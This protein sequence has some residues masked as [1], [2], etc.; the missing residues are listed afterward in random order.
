MIKFILQCYEE[1]HTFMNIKKGKLP[2]L[3]PVLFEVNETN[4]IAYVDLDTIQYPVTNIYY[5]VDFC[6]ER[7]LL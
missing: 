7:P 6:K 2:Q 3:N 5:S 4:S 1:F